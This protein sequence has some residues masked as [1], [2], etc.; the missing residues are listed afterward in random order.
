MAN[1]Q[2]R[3]TI[4]LLGRG[5]RKEGKYIAL[6]AATDGDPAPLTADLNETQIY[7]G[8]LVQ[9]DGSARAGIVDET[10]IDYL[11]TLRVC[12]HGITGYGAATAAAGETSTSVAG[13]P[14][15]PAFV[16][17]D[18]LHAKEITEPYSDGQN[19]VFE[20]M[21]RG[22]EV[23]ARTSHAGAIARG[24]YLESAGNGQ[25]QP[26]TA[27]AGDAQAEV[28]AASNVPAVAKNKR[29]SIV[30][31]AIEDSATSGTRFI[32]VEVV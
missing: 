3:R 30:A 28:A 19:I 31:R 26:V 4:L 15:I 29:A 20:V 12:N 5:I 17:E 18:E 32:H 16:V 10:G 8:N 13:E 24:T 9:F 6:R 25:L 21:P 22:S 14:A 7:P 27:T 1:V 23:L 11:E 2:N